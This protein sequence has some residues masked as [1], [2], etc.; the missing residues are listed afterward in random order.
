ML[1]QE[2]SHAFAK[3]LFADVE[4]EHA[5]QARRLLVNDRAVGRLG[6]FQIRDLLIDRRRAVRRVDPVGQRLDRLIEALPHRLRRLHFRQRV[7][8]HVLREAFLEPEVVEPAHRHQIAEPLMGQ[9]VQHR[10]RA[11]VVIVHRRHGPEQNHVFVEKRRAGMLHPAVGK[12]GDQH[13]IVF[14]E[15]E[16]A[17]RRRWPSA[18][19]LCASFRPRRAILPS[20]APAWICARTISSRSS[21]ASQTAPPQ[22]RTDRC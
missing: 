8:R 10:F 6:I 2:R 11:P 5:Q 17:A 19:C 20:R 16:T 22:T 4:R 15:R 12:S 21:Q 7:V 1:A 3:M 9:F 18:P 14:R 13:L